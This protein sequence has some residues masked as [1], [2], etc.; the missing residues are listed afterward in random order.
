MSNAQLRDTILTSSAHITY[1]DFQSGCH[2]AP[3]VTV[4]H[5]KLVGSQYSTHSDSEIPEAG[6]ITRYTLSLNS[7]LI[8]GWCTLLTP[9]V[10]VLIFQLL[11]H[12]NAALFLSSAALGPSKS[13]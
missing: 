2:I 7:I 13:F 3:I 9:E 8:N 6:R 10:F 4:R 1:K 12:R 11:L 5:H